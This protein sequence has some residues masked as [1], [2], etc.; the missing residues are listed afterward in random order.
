[1]I[2][3]FLFA[4][5]QVV[6]TPHALALATQRQID[7]MYFLYRHQ[8]GDWGDLCEEDR[9]SNEEALVTGARILSSYQ[10]GQEK[11]LDHH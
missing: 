5:G 9:A 8:T 6:S 11:N 10:I 1:M 7:L 2:K 4:L 3:H